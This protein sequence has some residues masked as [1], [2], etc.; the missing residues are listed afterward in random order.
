MR[1]KHFPFSHNNNN[2]TISFFLYFVFYV[3]AILG[4]E[5]LISV[6]D[7]RQSFDITSSPTKIYDWIVKEN[8][9]KR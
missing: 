6:N 5:T 2:K 8:Q 1:F 9:M 4:G 3:C 7:D